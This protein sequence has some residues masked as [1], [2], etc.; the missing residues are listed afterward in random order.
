MQS[1]SAAPSYLQWQPGFLVQTIIVANH[2]VHGIG[3]SFCSRMVLTSIKQREFSII[4]SHAIYGQHP[5]QTLRRDVLAPKRGLCQATS[6]RVVYH[7]S[8]Y[9]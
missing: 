7:Q 2:L 1:P 4:L 8:S 5:E 9:I 6:L 3:P